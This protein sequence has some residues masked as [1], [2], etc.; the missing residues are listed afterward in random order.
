MLWCLCNI[1]LVRCC[2]ERSARCVMHTFCF[3][4]RQSSWQHWGKGLWRDPMQWRLPNE[5]R[6]IKGPIVV[7][8]PPVTSMDAFR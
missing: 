8:A 7:P 6:R 5:E 4:H 3:S 2:I 1:S